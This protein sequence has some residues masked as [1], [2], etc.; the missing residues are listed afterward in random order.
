MDI[1][2]VETKRAMQRIDEKKRNNET[3]NWFFGKVKQD[4]QTQS[5]TNQKKEI[6]SKVIKLEMKK[7][8][9]H[10]YP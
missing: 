9:S 5:Q 3:K 4:S 7:E 8:M 10:R 2:E 6:R 1:N